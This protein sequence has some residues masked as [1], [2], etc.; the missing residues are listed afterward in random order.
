MAVRTIC[1]AV[2]RD[3]GSAAQQWKQHQ[4]SPQRPGDGGTGT[5]VKLNVHVSDVN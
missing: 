1:V 5:G 4:G 3:A 2:Q